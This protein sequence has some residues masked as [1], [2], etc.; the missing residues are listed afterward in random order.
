[1][2]SHDL[3]LETQGDLLTQT[4]GKDILLCHWCHSCLCGRWSGCCRCLLLAKP[5]SGVPGVRSSYGC[6]GFTS[7]DPFAWIMRQPYGAL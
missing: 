7:R 1:M 5:L 3:D 6:I 2:N 4:C